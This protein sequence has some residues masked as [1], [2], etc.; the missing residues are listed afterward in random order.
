MFG[1]R[2]TISMFAPWGP[3]MK[4]NSIVPLTKV[5]S[6]GPRVI[7]TPFPLSS[8][9]FV[10]ISGARHPRWSIAPSV[11]GKVSPSVTSTQTFPG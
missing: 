10:F 3:A 11:L 7:S 8:S 4:K 9:S 6:I 2:S 5:R 1:A